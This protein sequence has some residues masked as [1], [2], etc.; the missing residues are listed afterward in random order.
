LATFLQNYQTTYGEEPPGP[1]HAHTYDAVGV[2]LDALYNVGQVGPDGTLYIGR[3]ALNDAVRATSGYQGLS[4]VITCQ[5]NGDCGSGA[6]AIYV[7]ENGE[8]VTVQ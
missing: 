7:V 3:K 6:V 2:Y 4:G 8:F 5:P 1:F